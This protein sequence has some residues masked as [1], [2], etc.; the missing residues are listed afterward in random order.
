MT[1]SSLHLGPAYIPRNSVLGLCSGSLQR[2]QSY[3]C[4]SLSH[5]FSMQHPTFR[6]LALRYCQHQNENS[7][8]SNWTSQ[9]YY[10]GTSCDSST[11]HSL[12]AGKS[13]VRGGIPLPR[14]AWQGA[15]LGEADDNFVR[16][17]PSF[18]LFTN[19]LSNLHTMT[20]PAKKIK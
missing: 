20:F 14:K 3:T 4:S 7:F 17:C 19:F 18:Q 10:K 8:Q 5:R 9:E 2:T 1:T 6:K 16:G 11:A 13:H 12:R 15:R